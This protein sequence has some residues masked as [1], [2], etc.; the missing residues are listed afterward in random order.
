MLD[1]KKTVNI[2]RP[3]R[4]LYLDDYFYIAGDKQINVIYEKNWEEIKQLDLN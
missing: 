3:R 2:E 4:A 1:L